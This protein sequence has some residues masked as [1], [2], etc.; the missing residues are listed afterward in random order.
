METVLEKDLYYIALHI[1]KGIG[2]KKKLELLK[3]YKN[4]ENIFT[5]SSINLK[6]LLRKEN[7]LVD[8]KEKLIQAAE[9]E[10]KKCR[11]LGIH[12]VT[13]DQEHYPKNLRVIADPP[14]VLFYKGNLSDEDFN[15]IAVV[16]S[17]EVSDLGLKNSKHLSRELAGL[18]ITVVSG[19]ALGIDQSAHEAVLDG[20]G[21]TIAVIGSGLDQYYP[22]QNR[23]LQKEIADKGCLISEFPLGTKP[24]GKHFPIRNRIIAG[25]S[26]GV[27]VVEGGIDSGSLYTAKFALDYGRELYAFPGP[28]NNPNYSGNHD[29][30]KKGAKLIE[31]SYD[32]LNDLSLVL[33]LNFDCIQSTKI[34]SNKKETKMVNTIDL[35]K[36]KEEV[37]LLQD[38]MTIYQCL[39]N[40]EFTNIDFIVEET[41]LSIEK[42]MYNL[43]SLVLKDCCIQNG[44]EYKR[45][46]RKGVEVYG[47]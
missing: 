27:V 16:G 8:H 36:E 5:E 31:N 38:E 43:T 14:I 35:Q 46:V 7:D 19:L 23:E 10:I 44:N 6:Q 39:K 29:L 13:I 28:A 1:A 20:E 2:L 21:R 33:D 9:N 34:Q 40:E 12:I 15:S 22:P 11:D 42:V 47:K 25:L 37:H 45:N 24:L 3:K 17:R 32:L 26:V 4:I 30:I 18:G 41:E